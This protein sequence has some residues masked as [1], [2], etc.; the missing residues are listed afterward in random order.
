MK[1]LFLSFILIFFLCFQLLSA[2]DTTA[3]KQNPPKN[4]ER[5]EYL[6]KE[7]AQIKNDDSTKVDML[8]KIAFEIHSVNPYE[9][10]KYAQ[11]AMD[12]AE[13]LN[14]NS[15]ISELYGILAVSSVMKGDY[16]KFLE[17]LHRSIKTADIKSTSNWLKV[18]IGNIGNI[19]FYKDASDKAVEQFYKSIKIEADTTVKSAVIIN[20]GNI[21]N[22]NMG[23][24][25]KD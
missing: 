8:T 23:M 5:I 4:S 11:M 12:L 15:P 16:V 10:I 6:L 3:I 1:S 2:Q 25:Q 21:G 17:Y 19:N 20:I 9:G 13:K 22:I 24:K 14:Y 18:N 7:L